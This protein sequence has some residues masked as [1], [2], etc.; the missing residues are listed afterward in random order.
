MG[1]FLTVSEVSYQDF[2]FAHVNSWFT[3]IVMPVILFYFS[4]FKFSSLYRLCVP[5][6]YTIALTEVTKKIY[7][8]L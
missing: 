2:L 3:S 8:V 4:P 7:C 6:L 1:N 5:F